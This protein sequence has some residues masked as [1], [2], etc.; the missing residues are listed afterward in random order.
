MQEPDDGSKPPFF[1]CS[2]VPFFLGELSMDLSL[3]LGWTAVS[4][5]SDLAEALSLLGMPDLTNEN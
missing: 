1:A 5:V 2:Y 3:N 4:K